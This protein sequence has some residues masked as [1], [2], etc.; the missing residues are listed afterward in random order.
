MSTLN[1]LIK[2]MNTLFQVELTWEGTVARSNLL[3]S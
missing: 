3:I 1:L 2:D